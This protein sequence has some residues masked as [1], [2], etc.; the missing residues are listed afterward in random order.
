MWKQNCQWLK[1]RKVDGDKS[2]FRENLGRAKLLMVKDSKSRCRQILTESK[3]RRNGTKVNGLN[4][5]TVAAQWPPSILKDSSS[6]G[7]LWSQN[8]V[9][10]HGRQGTRRRGKEKTDKK[11]IFFG[12]T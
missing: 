9:N 4:A 3:W 10:F 11:Q 12:L 1:I 8:L 7:P 5:Q 6:G 2:S